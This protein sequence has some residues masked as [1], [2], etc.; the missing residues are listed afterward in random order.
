VVTNLGTGLPISGARISSDDEAVITDANGRYRVPLQPGTHALRATAPGYIGMTHVYQHLAGSTWL[1]LDFEMVPTDPN[2]QVVT[3]IQ[4]KRSLSSSGLP[5]MLDDESLQR[6]FELTGMQIA[7]STIRVLM[8]DDTVVVMP[9]EEY[10][11]GVVPNEVYTWWP[12]DTLKAQSIAARCYASAAVA[13][14]RH[15]DKGAD[16]CTTQHCQV[17]EPVYADSTDQAVAET[18]GVIATYEGDVISAFYFSHCDGHTH[19]SEEDFGSFVPYCRSVECP[20]D[21]R[22]PPPYPGH[23]VGMCQWGA[24]YAAD[25]QHFT[26]SEI[27]KH[28]Y[29]DIDVKVPPPGSVTVPTWSNFT[30][31]TFTLSSPDATTVQLSN[32]WVWE[33]VA[34][35]HTTNT[36]IIV[37]DSDALNRLAWYGR[38][39]IDA[40]GAWFGPYTCDL[41]DSHEYGIYFRLKTPDSSVASGLATL[42][43]V[44]NH[45][46]RK[47][48]ERAITATDFIQDNTYEEF[49]LDLVY[50]DTLPTC[51]DPDNGDGLEFRTWFSSEGDLYLDRITVFQAPQPLDAAISWTVRDVEGSQTVIVRFLDDAG[52]ATDHTV[53]INLDKTL[54]VWS[55]YEPRTVWV[56]DALSGLDTTSAAWATSHDDGAT[57]DAW[58]SLSVDAITGTRAIQLEAPQDPG[59]LLRFRIQDMAG[60]VSESA[61]QELYETVTPT[62]T[63]TPTLTATITPTVT[64]TATPSPSVSPTATSTPPQTIPSETS[65]PTSTMPHRW[66]MPLILKGHPQ[67]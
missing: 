23:M 8:L 18:R 33:E 34:L 9:M 65:T 13:N 27:L 58:Q 66:S 6:G 29:T 38:A 31:I 39:G 59:T 25:E 40:P 49:H 14:P 50:T 51:Q 36:G 46:Q 1:K 55:N 11:R 45:G 4:A 19:N 67:R 61:P 26:Y 15:A 20:C 62:P 24:F 56:E 3:A 10:L 57:W 64:L 47:Y 60:N 30:Q 22:R 12:M 63:E 28:F 2:P 53:L 35:T 44:D 48:A 41:A 37:T 32:D 54:P 42:D 43:I 5:H 21:G 17:W 16:I 52:N 7:P